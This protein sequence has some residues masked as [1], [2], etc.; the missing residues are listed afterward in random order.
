[1]SAWFDWLTM[2][3]TYPAHPELSRR[4]ERLEHLN[5][6]DGKTCVASDSW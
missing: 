1:M 4:I 2:R 3:G 5:L 6:Y